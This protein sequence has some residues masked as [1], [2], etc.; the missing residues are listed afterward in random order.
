MWWFSDLGGYALLL[1][2]MVHA[3]R[4]SKLVKLVIIVCYFSNCLIDIEKSVTTEKIYYVISC[5]LIFVQIEINYF[6]LI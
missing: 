6:D 2:L 5:H 1:R 4:I 3:T